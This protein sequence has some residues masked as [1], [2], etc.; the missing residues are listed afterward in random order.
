LWTGPDDGWYGTFATE[1]RAVDE[2][3]ACV[4]VEDMLR[5]LYLQVGGCR[6]TS[7]AK[8]TNGVR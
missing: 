7:K 6:A 1:M 2:G 3:V 4:A 5:W 8:H